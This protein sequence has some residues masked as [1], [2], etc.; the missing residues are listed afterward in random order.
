MIVDYIFV[1]WK[2]SLLTV[3]KYVSSA[4]CQPS[5]LRSVRWIFKFL[6]S[7]W[8]SKPTVTVPTHAETK[9]QRY[10]ETCFGQKT[11]PRSVALL[12]RR[13]L[14]STWVPDTGYVLHCRVRPI[15]GTTSLIYTKGGVREG[16]EN[17][18]QTPSAVPAQRVI[19]VTE[20]LVGIA[21]L[22]LL[23]SIACF[24]D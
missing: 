17:L 12:W 22:P 9:L 19:V 15:D 14:A 8:Q 20:I 5:A 2:I 6:I 7:D 1:F 10:G 18:Q 21:A 13:A 11:R 24:Y 3:H 23:V 4:L 16:P